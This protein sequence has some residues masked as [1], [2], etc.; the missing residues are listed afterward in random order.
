[1][2]LVHIIKKAP[3][4]RER[5]DVGKRE[6]TPRLWAGTLCFFS[7]VSGESFDLSL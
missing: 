4:A 7:E 6:E 2:Y 3:P 1:M 5:L